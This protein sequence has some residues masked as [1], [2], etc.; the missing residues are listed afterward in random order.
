M[1]HPIVHLLALTLLLFPSASRAQPPEDTADVSFRQG[2]EL[3]RQGQYQAAREALARAFALKQTFDIA[4]ALGFAEIKLEHWRAAAT[5]LAWALRNWAPTGKAASR[6]SAA[7]WLD[8]AKTHI[9]TLTILVDRGADVAVDGNAV[10]KAPLD[11]SVFVEPGHHVVAAHLGAKT[12]NA[13]VEVPA[14]ATQPVR[15]ALA[16]ASDAVPPTAR[17]RVPVIVLGTVSGVAAAVG[18][19]TLAGF[20]SKMSSVRSQNDAILKAHHSCIANAPNYDAACS[21]LLSTASAG[22]KLADASIGLLVSAGVAAGG[23]LLYAFWP[24]TGHATQSTGGLH[25][26]PAASPTGVWVGASGTF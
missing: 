1:R 21:T 14:G 8:V 5:S 25:I 9:A 4:A 10:G 15:L 24:Q 18:I 7:H 23:A 6:E 20:A 26:T 16:A 2:T 11:D 19:G 12:A 13:D 17:S 3:Y 22:D